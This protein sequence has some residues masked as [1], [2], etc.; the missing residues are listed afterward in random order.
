MLLAEEIRTLTRE[1]DVIARAQSGDQTAF[2]ELY[3][4]HV[5]RVYALCLRLAGNVPR[6]EELTQDVFVRLWDVL[7]TF[8]S[9]SAFSTWLYR[10]AMNHVLVEK[11]SEKR[12]LARVMSTDTP[13]Q[14]EQASRAAAAPQQFDLESAIQKLPTQARAVFV[15]HDVE[16][17]PHEEIAHQ[18]G[19]TTGTTKSQLHRARKLLREALDQ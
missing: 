6:A 7:P 11:R 8:R 9:E 14:Y 13:E 2:A 3:R 15:L 12:R 1:A 18:L 17:Y 19:I 10:V 5:G 4:L 16:G